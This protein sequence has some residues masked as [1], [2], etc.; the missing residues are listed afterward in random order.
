MVNGGNAVKTLLELRL[1]HNLTI[2]EASVGAGVSNNNYN[3]YEKGKINMPAYALDN[4]CKFY[5]ISRDEVII[6]DRNGKIKP[7]SP[8]LTSV[9]EIKE[10][11]EFFYN[12]GVTDTKKKLLDNVDSI[13]ESIKN[14]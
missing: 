4:I 8:S 5:G 6:P 2:K 1:E 14:L 3:G 13:F 11:A 7:Q 9:K 12:K 10:N